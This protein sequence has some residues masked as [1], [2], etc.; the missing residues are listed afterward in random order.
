MSGSSRRVR[1]DGSAVLQPGRVAFIQPGR[2]AGVLPPV[3]TTRRIPHRP[4]Q[5][6][7]VYDIVYSCQTIGTIPTRVNRLHVRRL[8]T[9]QD[10]WIRSPSAWLSHRHS[11]WPISGC[12]TTSPDYSPNSSATSPATDLCTIPPIHT[13]HSELS[14]LG[15]AG[16]QVSPRH[17]ERV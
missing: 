8:T 12:V 2:L 17:F 16:C 3:P 9:C 14:S 15:Y 10:R 1:A 6:T 5:R 11:A 7:P 13:G 4:A